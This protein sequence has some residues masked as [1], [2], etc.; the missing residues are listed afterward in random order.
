[1]NTIFY[2][3]SLYTEEVLTCKIAGEFTAWEQ[4]S[5]EWDDNK[6]V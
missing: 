6:K 4:K 5:M 2:D 3:P 1:M